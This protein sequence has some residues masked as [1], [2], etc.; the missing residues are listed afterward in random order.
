MVSGADFVFDSMTE[1]IKHCSHYS[2]AHIYV[3][4][5]D[6]FHMLRSR[7]VRHPCMIIFSAGTVKKNLVALCYSVQQVSFLLNC[8]VKQR[9]FGFEY[10]N[11]Y[12]EKSYHITLIHVVLLSKFIK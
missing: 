12:N 7:V 10:E 3:D 8:C 4:C 2:T 11:L 6:A 5:A 1:F 9:T